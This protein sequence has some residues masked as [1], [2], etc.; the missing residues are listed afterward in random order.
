MLDSNG[1]KLAAFVVAVAVIG[2]AIITGAVLLL[3]TW[4]GML[5]GGIASIVF[6]L[7]AL[8]LTIGL[9]TRNK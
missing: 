6:I 4:F 8:F 2:T 7:V 9:A 1:W 5:F 3:T